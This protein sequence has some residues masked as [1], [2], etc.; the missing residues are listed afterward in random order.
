MQS[1]DI[2]PER[3][4]LITQRLILLE[5]LIS[6]GFYWKN[7]DHVIDILVHIIKTDV[8]VHVPSTGN[9]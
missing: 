2:K 4:K 5:R 7:P 9:N 1:T 6:Y 3:E 8:Q